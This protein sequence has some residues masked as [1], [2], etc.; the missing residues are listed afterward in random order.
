MNAALVMTEAGLRVH[1]FPSSAAA[2]AASADRET[3]GL[4]AVLIKRVCAWCKMDMGVTVGSPGQ[5]DLVTHGMCPACEAR[6]LA[7]LPGVPAVSKTLVQGECLESGVRIRCGLDN[8]DAGSPAPSPSRATGTSDAA[9]VPANTPPGAEPAQVKG[10]S[11]PG[12]Y[13]PAALEHLSGGPAASSISKPS[14][15]DR[16]DCWIKSRI[17]GRRIDA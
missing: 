14:L 6:L 2:K 4:P 8:A 3:D 16:F 9:A 17:A 12:A 5:Q 1:R 13:E 11:A 7:E 15:F 10:T